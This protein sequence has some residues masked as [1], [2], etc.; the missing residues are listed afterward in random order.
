[1][2]LRLIILCLAAWVSMLANAQE[3]IITISKDSRLSK[4][5]ALGGKAAIIFMSASGDLVISSTVTKDPV[6]DMPVMT[7]KGYEYKMVLDISGGRDRVFNISKKGTT[8]SIKTGQVL[9]EANKCIGFNVEIVSN[10]ITMEASGEGGHYIQSGNGWALIE[11]NSEIKLN[12]AFS[13]DLHAI[14]KSGVS[15]AGTYIDSLIIRVSDLH[16]MTEELGVKNAYVEQMDAQYDSLLQVQV[17]D[18]ELD[19]QEQKIKSAKDE[20]EKLAGKLNELTYISIKG[21]GTNERTIDPEEILS[22]GSKDKKA[23][24]VMALLKTVSVFK[25]K[26]E[27]MINQAVSH[28]NTRDYMSAKMY[29]ENAA[30]VEDA[31]E[32]DKQAALQSAQQMEKL[33]KFKEETDAIADKLYELSANNKIVNKNAFVKMIDDMVDR[34]NALHKETGDDFYQQEALRLEKE[35]DDIG[36]VFKGRVVYSEYKS[37]S[38]QETPLSNVVIY[39]SMFSKNEDMDDRDYIHKGEI[40]ETEVDSE[41]R[42]SFTLKP[43]QYK[44]IIFEV[45]GDKKIKK[46]KH[47]SLEGR[48]GDR[49]VKVRFAKD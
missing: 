31:S 11:I 21:D 48:T 47:V 33:A 2:K 41:G 10:P 12:L 45:H 26:Y 4:E 49:N 34:Y 24:K 19:A 16:A 39:G 38:I 7:N 28:K 27:E 23:Y 22:L 40:I 35:K 46:N 32:S 44:T 37:G 1:M 42:F 5:E 43:G 15:K 6:C 20:V 3:S 13:P 8:F 29:Y 30:K 17:S 25:T 14:H 36:F 9:L 18:A